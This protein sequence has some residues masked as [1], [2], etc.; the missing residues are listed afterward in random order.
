MEAN[1]RELKSCV[2]HNKSFN[3]VKIESDKWNALLYKTIVVKENFSNT[4]RIKRQVLSEPIVFH[5]FVVCTGT[6]NTV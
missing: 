6:E 3:N 5:L 4:S 2:Y 1:A